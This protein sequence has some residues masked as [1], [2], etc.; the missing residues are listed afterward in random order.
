MRYHNHCLLFVALA[1]FG[2]S[3]TEK[4]VSLKASAPNDY[5]D[6]TV[7]VTTDDGIRKTSIRYWNPKNLPLLS[8]SV[9][10]G[11]TVI[12]I[13]K[14]DLSTPEIS[15]IPYPNFFR[16]VHSE[17]VSLFEAAIGRTEKLQLGGKMDYDGKGTIDISKVFRDPLVKAGQ[18]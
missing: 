3:S 5:V 15:L 6:F 17:G 8:L 2:C 16:R 1:V 13:R 18:P 9:I 4:L 7:K 14:S 10:E 11:S 12:D